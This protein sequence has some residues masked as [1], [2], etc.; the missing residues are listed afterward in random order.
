MRKKFKLLMLSGVALL[1][2]LTSCKLNFVIDL[3]GFSLED[4]LTISEDEAN[5]IIQSFDPSST[6][7]DISTISLNSSLTEID[8]ETNTSTK[9]E[10]SLNL[11]DDMNSLSLSYSYKYGSTSNSISLSQSNDSYVVTEDGSSTNYTLQEAYAYVVEF[12]ESIIESY[13]YSSNSYFTNVIE[14]NNIKYYSL[15]NYIRFQC[16]LSENVTT[17]S[18]FDCAFTHDGLFVAGY[19]R[20]Y[21]NLELYYEYGAYIDYNDQQSELIELFEQYF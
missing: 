6:Y 12:K 16:V 8:L 19:I 11:D 14:E 1:G 9:E 21:A 5:T 2:V 15:S 3:S 18:Y 20:K 4:F 10:I 7:D 17:Y 13:S